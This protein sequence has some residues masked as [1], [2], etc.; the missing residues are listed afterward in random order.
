[1][2]AIN[3]LREPLFCAA[4]DGG[5]D[6]LERPHHTDDH[7][8][9]CLHTWPTEETPV[10]EPVNPAAGRKTP[11]EDKAEF[12]LIDGGRSA[13]R[14]Q[15][16][17]E[18]RPGVISEFDLLGT[19]NEP[20]VLTVKPGDVLLVPNH[21]TTGAALVELLGGNRRMVVCDDLDAPWVIRAAPA[22]D[23]L[24]VGTRVVVTVDDRPELF[25]RILAFVPGDGQDLEH[26]YVV[27]LDPSTSGAGLE[28]HWARDITVHA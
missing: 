5:H 14:A 22:F 26:S 25:G 1:M 7:R 28:L 3:D 16:H 24:P 10:T 2:I 20:H 8:C 11:A 19:P 23:A 27:D 15:D 6:C 17:L 18:F 13:A 21:G 4:Q 9:H 12:D